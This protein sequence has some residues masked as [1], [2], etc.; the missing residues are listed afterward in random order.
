MR[1][2]TTRSEA[3]DNRA[4]V[5]AAVGPR[6]E[7]RMLCSKGR[8]RARP[9]ATSVK[10]LLLERVPHCMPP[11]TANRERS[12]SRRRGNIEGRKER[13]GRR[14]GGAS[15]V[16]GG[17]AGGGRGAMCGWTARTSPVVIYSE[18]IEAA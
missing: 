1:A 3:A 14:G 6:Q 2:P 5:V 10:G 4:A 18:E 16:A 9:T 13:R 15:E 7:R 12:A 17:R 11:T 8:V